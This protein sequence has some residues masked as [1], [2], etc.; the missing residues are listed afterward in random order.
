MAEKK[1]EKNREEK[2]NGEKEAATKENTSIVTNE[3]RSKR[4][5]NVTP[6]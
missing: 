3:I 2:R 4:I 6:H 5:P 1:G